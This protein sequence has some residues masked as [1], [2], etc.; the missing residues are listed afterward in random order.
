MIS[1]TVYGGCGT[2]G[3][4]KILLEDHDEDT[5]LF[6]DFGTSFKVR[7][8]FFEEYLN[9]RPGA[10]LLDLLEM[11]YGTYGHLLPPLEGIYRDDFVPAGD[12]WSRYRDD[13]RFRELPALDGVLVSHAHVDHTGYI[14]FLRPEIPVY[15]S[16]MSAFIAKAMQ[17]SMVPHF[18]K[19]VCYL[20]ER[21][22]KAE[23]GGREVLRSEGKLPLRLRPFVF[24]DG[25]G[26]NGTAQRFWQDTPYKRQLESP[27][28]LPF[29]QHAVEGVRVGRLPVR[30]Y[31]VDHSIHGASAWA[32]ETS[33]GW[34]VY[35]GDL[36]LHGTRGEDTE[37]F[38]AAAR[39]LQPRVLLCEGTRAPR[40]GDETE[41]ALPSVTEQEVEDNAGREVARE[42]G[43]VVADFGP[44]NI[45]RLLAFLRIAQATGRT[46]VVLAKDAYL[47]DAMHL[48]DP[49]VPTLETEPALRVYGDLKSQPL[50]AERLV[51]RRHKGKFVLPEEIR[52]NADRFI[53]CFSFWD[54]KNLIDIDPAAGT[55]IYSS[56]EAYTEE[57]RLDI[58]RLRHWLDHF[59]LRG[60][61]LPRTS[62]AEETTDAPE[63][64]EPGQEKLH[65]SGHAAAADLAALAKEI[66]PQT[67]VPIHTEN[68]RFFQALEHEGIEIRVPEYAVPIELG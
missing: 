66:R 58:W 57:Q 16:A 64:F 10:G 34:V 21:I 23:E 14:S 25:G 33:A 53:L 26:L 51:R 19:E 13:R 5:R 8:Q 22:P 15:T 12:I 17:D 31:P 3:G 42:T 67:L 60:I 55:Y 62:N 61:G 37:R 40:R 18:E 20:S 39:A 65:A 38:I 63:E 41:P 50:S 2:V 49:S 28:V 44:R 59:G 32:V 11:E 9:P 48:V 4:N 6:F 45:E 30:H 1:L 56:S 36:R 68:P 54:V 27:T 47:L 35:T 52:A 29:Q 46:L 7:E 24:M 43:L